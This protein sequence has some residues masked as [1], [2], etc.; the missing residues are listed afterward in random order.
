M[1]ARGPAILRPVVMALHWTA[2][3]MIVGWLFGAVPPVLI[4]GHAALWGTI[5]VLWGLRGGPSPALRGAMRTAAH[6][7]HAALLGLYLVGAAFALTDPSL[8]RP[9]LLAT[10][11]ASALHAVWNLYRAGVLGDGA[12][13]RMLP[14]ALH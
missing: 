12:F 13:R 1:A 3:P 2:L 4:A 6:L 8:A 14:K 10:L 9:V 11:A 5:T 7:S